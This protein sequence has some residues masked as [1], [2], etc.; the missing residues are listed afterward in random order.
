MSTQLIDHNEDLKKL[1]DEDVIDIKYQI[2][3]M[4][5]YKDQIYCYSALILYRD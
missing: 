2:S 4:Y 1:K 3:T 5:D